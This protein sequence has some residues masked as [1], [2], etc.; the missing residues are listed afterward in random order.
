MA[1]S[2]KDCTINFNLSSSSAS[3]CPLRKP[4]LSAFRYNKSQELINVN[5]HP[6]ALKLRMSALATLTDDAAKLLLTN[7]VALPYS[8]AEGTV[9]ESD[10]E[11]TSRSLSSFS[12]CAGSL[13]SEAGYPHR[14]SICA[15]W[16]SPSSAFAWFGGGLGVRNLVIR[17]RVKL[18]DRKIL[19]L[20]V[21]RAF[22]YGHLTHTCTHGG[23]PKKK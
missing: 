5:E 12:R 20:L 6:S 18:E 21:D 1:G 3:Q 10:S 23:I 16:Q 7:N 13:Q 15:A 4:G 9:H 14:G 17:L 22:G 19:K 8:T 11:L 2:G